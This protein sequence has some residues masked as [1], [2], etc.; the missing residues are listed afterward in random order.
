MAF[1]TAANVAVDFKLESTFNTVPTASGA[2]RFRPNAGAGISLKR[3][4]IK[5]NEIRPD[6]KTSMPRLGSK[7]ATGGYAGDAS[8]GTFDIGF[9]AVS[10]GTWVA[11]VVLTQATGTSVT[12]TAGPPGTIVRASGSWLT[13]GVRVGDVVRLNASGGPAANNN[14]NLRVTAVVALTLTVADTLTVDATP[15]TTYTLTIAKKVTQPAVPVFRSFTFEEKHLDIGKAEQYTGCRWSSLRVVGAPNGMCTLDFGIVGANENPLNA[16][17][18]TS[19]TQSTT[20]GLTM[21]D[22]TLRLGGVDVATLSSFDMMLDTHC[23]TLPIIGSVVTPD[24]FGGAAELSGSIQGTRQDF[25]NLNAFINE[26]ELELHVLLV[27]P[28]SEPKDFI[29]FFVP[30]VKLLGAD[31]P[32]GSSGAM[33]ETCNWI[34]GDKEVATGYDDTLCCIATSAP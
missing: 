5:P 33:I 25:T 28:Q 2:S 21:V 32:F 31:A 12:A 16:P 3:A 24:V 30:R 22:A 10:R 19:P 20:I 34:A 4:L 7:E 23:S 27:A 26:T 17:F 9:E 18:F 1:Q 6:M 15:R 8:T 11:A 29:S 13:D 14:R